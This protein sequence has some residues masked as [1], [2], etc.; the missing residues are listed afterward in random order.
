[1]EREASNYN[2]SF[3]GKAPI[4]FFAGRVSSAT[5]LVTQEEKEK[6]KKNEWPGSRLA[7]KKGRNADSAEEEICALTS[8]SIGGKR[9]DESLLARSGLYRKGRVYG[10]S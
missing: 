9:P 2:L 10:V 6:V 1:V 8:Y 7:D 3:G 4:P 5:R